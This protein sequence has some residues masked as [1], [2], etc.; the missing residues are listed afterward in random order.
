[1][2]DQP[3]S[4]SDRRDPLGF[5]EI[6]ALLIAFSAVGAVLWW[7]IGRSADSWVRRGFTPRTGE[8]VP[9]VD[10]ALSEEAIIPTTPSTERSRII[11]PTPPI[12]EATRRSRAVDP[13]VIA[14]AVVAPAVIG[15]VSTPTVPPAVPTEPLASPPPIVV[16]PVSP[17]AA[18]GFPDVPADYWAF[19]FITELS[20]R[21]VISGFDDGTFQP[22]QPLTRAQYAALIEQVLVN[23]NQN[24]IDFTDIPANFWGAPAVDEAVKAGFLKGY[25]DA[26]FQPNQPISK[27]QVLLSLANGFRLP[28]STNPDAALQL[29]QDR[30]QIPD[31]AQ[32]AVAAAAESSVVV[33]YPNRN[34]LAPNQSTTRAEVAAML[35]QALTATGQLQPIQSNY[36]VRP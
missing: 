7:S 29:F 10:P 19:P 11:A 1:M 17:Q 34:Q 26:S 18:V 13:R 16:P 9:T 30:G 2:S 31:W 12:P 35:Y 3:R 25:P 28:R 4:S 21:G 14:P 36:I 33:N 6:L 20:R 8:V 32:P 5:D 23:E 24:P 22:E 15:G 27:M